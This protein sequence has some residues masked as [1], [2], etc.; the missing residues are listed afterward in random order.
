M[1]GAFDLRAILARKEAYEAL[2]PAKAPTAQSEGAR[3]LGLPR[4]APDDVPDLTAIYRTPHGTMRLRDVQNA[5]LHQ[6]EQAQGLF[7]PV[8]VGGGKGLFTMLAPMVLKAQRPLL[9]L[10]ANL[11]ETF[12][13][14]YRKFRPHFKLASHLK[15]MTYSALSV[16]SGADFLMRYQP[17]FIVCDEAHNLRHLTSTRTK[18]FMRYARQFPLT[19]YA[20][21][22]G[23]M[24]KRGL[25]DYAH[26][27]E[28]A[29]GDRAP[30]PLQLNELLSWANVLDADGVP[31]DSDWTTINRA[32]RPG[33]PTRDVP[34][35]RE[36]YAER[37]R[38]TP[39]VVAS[40]ESELGVGLYFHEM[41]LGE[42]EVVKTARLELE[43]TWCRP[44]GEELVDAFAVFRVEQQ[45]SSGFYYVWDWPGGRVDQEWMDKR[46]VWNKAVRRILKAN[47]HRWDSPLRVALALSHGTLVDTQALAAYEDWKG[48]R[49]RPQPPTKAVWLS[50]FMVR[51]AGS[52]VLEQ[53]AKKDGPVT[54]WYEHTALGLALEQLGLPL[55]GAGA[56]PELSTDEALASSITAHGTGKNLQRTHTMLVL[57]WPRSGSVVEQLVG[58]MHRPGQ[59]AD[60]VN[61]HYVA[62]TPQARTSLRDSIND[63]EYV[64]QSMGTRRKVEL[65][66]WMPNTWSGSDE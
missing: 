20:F 19:K 46:Q 39:G 60:A 28:L 1:S 29:L 32:L 58:R 66:T 48:V 11:Q 23:T 9:L 59:L 14:E 45:L 64:E 53:L 65:G 34:T 17:D 30:I 7:G 4:W 43:R 24:T 57:N 8:G 16:N 63:E 37:F 2:L 21:I 13:L 3:I 42:P 26:L 61:V 35:I 6:L 54:V 41:P 51:A 12:H 36:T 27:I 47:D 55:F 15:I 49:A 38:A 31:S 56:N 22:S 18:R 62:H 44:D 33:S 25:K 52:W 5:M 50:D 40:D 10:P